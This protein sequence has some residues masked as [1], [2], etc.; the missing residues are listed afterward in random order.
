MF[1]G[2]SDECSGTGTCEVTMSTAKSVTATF[3]TTA[4]T[5][6]EEEAAA[7]KKTEEEG[8]ATKKREEE[9]GAKEKTEEEAAAAARKS[10]EEAALPGLITAV[11]SGELGPSGKGAKI[12]ALLKSGGLTLEFKA[13]EA[14]TAVINWYE[15]QRGAGPAKKSK[16]K[17]VLLAS[18]RRTFSAAG[19]AKLKIELTAAGKGLLKHA[20]EARADRQGHVHRSGQN[21]DHGYQD[22]RAQTL[23]GSWR[24]NF[25]RCSG[26][27]P[28]IAAFPAR[29]P[30]AQ[31]RRRGGD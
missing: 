16:P 4:V 23:D 20:E 26:G 15:L 29:T 1:A 18:G 9:A 21:G 3:N 11:L 22:G 5:K 31:R 30:S 27:R 19:T 13:L 8:A 24:N 17:L 2:W 12:A 7:K 14:G 6:H 10:A 25:P 28:V